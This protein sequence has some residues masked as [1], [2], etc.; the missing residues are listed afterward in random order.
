MT[1]PGAADR[2]G[3]PVKPV[4][5]ESGREKI[6]DRPRFGFASANPQPRCVL[7]FQNNKK[8]GDLVEFQTYCDFFG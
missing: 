3:F 5:S 8:S 4:E 2:L 7:R 6:L 1:S